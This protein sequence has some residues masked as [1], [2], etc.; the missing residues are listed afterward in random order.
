MFDVA[1]LI[2]EETAVDNIGNEIKKQTENEVFIDISSVSQNEFYKSAQN[3]LKS[4][5]KFTLFSAD[6]GG[7]EKVRYNDTVYYIYRTYE[8]D[9]KTELYVTKKAGI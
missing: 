3:G 8:K 2:N 9:E 4:E 5:Y 6:Y 1:Y 7:Q